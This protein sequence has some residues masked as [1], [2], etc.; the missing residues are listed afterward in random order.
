MPVR[1]NTMYTSKIENIIQVSKEVIK[2]SLLENGA[3]VAANTTKDYYP[4][5]AQN[6]FYV[7]PRDASYVC[8]AADIVGIE[9]IQER[10]FNWCF[11]RAEGFKE[12]GLFYNKYYVNGLK[13]LNTF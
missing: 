8:I 10:F 9:G 13:G 6:Y 7:W 2:D 3:I 12:T 5:T 1:N 11:E 4:S